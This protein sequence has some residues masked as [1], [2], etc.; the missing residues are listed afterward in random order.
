MDTTRN[1]PTVITSPED[2]LAAAPG[3]MG[4]ELDQSILL[5]GCAGPRAMHARVDLPRCS[6]DDAQ[7]LQQFLPAALGND[8]A[9]V[10]LIVYT[11]DVHSAARF[12]DHLLAA[13]S[14]EGIQVIIALRVDRGRW[15]ALVDG[16][17]GARPEGV[18]FD[19][20]SHPITAQRVLEGRRVYAS[21]A[22]LAAS[23]DPDLEAVA[24]V[25]RALR[26]ARPVAGARAVRRVRSVVRRHSR[27]RR[28]PSDAVVAEVVSAL[29]DDMTVAH[30]VSAM[31]R[32]GAAARL[33]FW[34][35]VLRRTPPEHVAQVAGVTAVAAW[36]A[37]NGALAWCAVD[38]SVAGG[39]EHPVAT[40]VGKLLSCGVP[41]DVWG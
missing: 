11:D 10:A 27:S 13:C 25:E 23:L 35:G 33:E 6:E 24:A 34:I 29:A 2:F 16:V 30:I 8:V 39:H 28:P 3:A 5:L 19:I 32:E 15:Y 12:T 18:P 40:M 41:P 31:D 22:E 36:L 17:V 38:R 20:S 14:R 4:F 37:G 26:E 9:A 7:V 1:Q 21:R